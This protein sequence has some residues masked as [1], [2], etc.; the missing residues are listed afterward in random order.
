MSEIRVNSIIAEGGSSAPNLAY[1]AQVPTGMGITGAGGINVTGVVTA[2]S[3]SGSGSGLTGVGTDN[4]N[5]NNAKV[6]GI[7]TL[8]TTSTIVGSAVTFNAS[9]GTI[10]GVLTATSFEGSGANLTGVAATDNINTNNIQVSGITTFQSLQE[11]FDFWL[12]G[13]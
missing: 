4:L 10:V 5:T 2:T 1:G 3:F 13:G 11:P 12:Y 7:T 8:G 6:S 9:G